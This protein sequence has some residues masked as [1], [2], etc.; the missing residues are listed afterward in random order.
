[1]FGIL[2]QNSQQLTKQVSYR[3]DT[4]LAEEMGISG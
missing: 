1:M 3:E 4:V 2:V